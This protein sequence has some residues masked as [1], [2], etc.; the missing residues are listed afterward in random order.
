MTVAVL[1]YDEG[2]DVG[3]GHRRRIEAIASS[4]TA[5][6]LDIDLGPAGPT[7]P[8]NGPIV[9]LDSYRRRADDAALV[10]GDTVVAL[11]DLHRDLAVDLLVEPG[12][13]ADAAAPHAAREVLAGAAYSIVD[14]AL[15]E[16]LTSSITDAP[17]VVLVTLG[18]A[19]GSGDLALRIAESIAAHTPGIEVRVAGSPLTP[20]SRH[21][22]V[23]PQA[24]GLDAELARADIVVTAGGVTLLE[25]LTLG[26]P[27]VAL[28]TAPNQRD[29]LDGVA[30]AS[31]A[32]FASAIDAAEV[33][34]ELLGDRVRR[35]ALGA[36]GSEL[37]DGSGASRVAN[38][39][40]RLHSTLGS[41]HVV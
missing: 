30:A 10:Q 13:G 36:A 41:R 39:I 23:L 20:P 35:E 40:V 22:I 18:G 21:V 12:P 2:P 3:F 7:D 26:R 37:I 24:A 11:D 25:A 1:R 27:V 33:V 14:P 29:N 17:H 4:L 32:L 28:E 34:C 38:A 16:R 9:V 15:R 6:H 8:I 19:S 5:I 31:A